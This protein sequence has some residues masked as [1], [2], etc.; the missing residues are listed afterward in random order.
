RLS[1]IRIIL[2]GERGSGK[3]S[4]GDTI[5]GREEFDTWRVTEECVKRQSE[6]AMRQI[7]VVDTPDWDEWLIGNDPQQIRQEIVPLCPPGPHTLLLVIDLDSN[8]DWRSVKEHLD[9]LS[10]RVWRHTIVLFTWGDTLRDTDI[11]QHIER[12][13]KNLQ[14]LVEKCGNRYHVLNNKNRGDRTQVTE[15]LEKI[16]DMVAGNYG[17]YFTTDI[18]HLH[19]EL[20]KYIRQREEER[21]REIEE[22][23][24][25]L[26]PRPSELRLVLL[27]RTGAG[28]SAAGNTLLGSTQF[29]SR[30]SLSAVT[31]TCE[32]RRGEAAG[33]QLS[34]IDTPGLLDSRG[35]QR[36]VCLEVRRCLLL[37]SPGPHAFLLV[38]RARRFTDEEKGALLTVTEVF[39]EAVLNCTVVLF[40]HGDSLGQE[41]VEQY[42]DTQGRDLQQLL[43]SCGNRYHVLN[44]MDTGDRTQVTQL[45]EKI[46][47]MVARNNRGFFVDQDAEERLRERENRY[48]ESSAGN[49]ILGR[50]EFDTEGVTEE[51]ERRQG[52]VAGR[53]ITVVDTPGWHLNN[54]KSTSEWVKQETVYSVSL[55][56]PG[57]HALLLVIPLITL[58]EKQRRVEKEHL[59]LLSK[60]VWRHTIV[61]F[62]CGDTLTHTTIE[63]HIER[64]GKKLQCLMEKCGNRYHVLNNKNRGDRTQV[65][66]LLE[67]IEDMVTGMSVFPYMKNRKLL[68][69]IQKRKMAKKER[70]KEEDVEDEERGAGRVPVSRR[71]SKESEPPNCKS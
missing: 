32:R 37:S 3:S 10:K 43:E 13:G 31:Q 47:D 39:G 44:N 26:Q 56:P 67:K 24:Q 16:E 69:K 15:L 62:S 27:G 12:R 22:L 30:P 8:T 71:H 60:T 4:A 5:L 51:C 19:T 53:Q 11:E 28:K 41:T 55:C 65:T 7:T 45:L 34:V 18:E 57:P 48:R 50:E 9:L 21:Q 49:T 1:E 29:P 58:T 23:R 38:L 64:G 63:Q 61:L 33:R 68:Q 25:R 20:D 52:E 54:I 14:G 42:I 70:R 59:Q 6:V 17:Q 66:E 2:L 36:D 35:R 40:T 46:E